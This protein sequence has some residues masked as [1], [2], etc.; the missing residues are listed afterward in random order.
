MRCKVP[1]GALKWI[2]PSVRRA[3]A[4]CY[5]VVHLRVLYKKIKN[6]DKSTSVVRALG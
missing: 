4:D 3:F 2:V 5:A 1:V 6:Q